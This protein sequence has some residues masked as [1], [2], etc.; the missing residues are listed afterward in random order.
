[1]STLASSLLLAAMSSAVAAASPSSQG[2]NFTAQ[3]WTAFL[4]I[5]YVDSERQV[6]HTE[7]SET[8]RFGSNGVREAAGV[9]VEV[10]SSVR[11][12]KR[13]GAPQSLNGHTEPEF[14]DDDDGLDRSGC[15]PPFRQNYPAGEAWIAVIRRGGCTFNEK[16]SNVLALNASGV[17]IYDNEGSCLIMNIIY[18]IVN[19][20]T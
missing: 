17:L 10:I 3:Y 15:T 9:A 13:G 5:S 2:I 14:S 11:G 8:G 19:L 16:I 20:G 6:W 7:R 18:E 1:M 12:P 4:N